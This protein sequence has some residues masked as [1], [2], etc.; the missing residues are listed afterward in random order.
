MKMLTI[1]ALSMLTNVLVSSLGEGRATMQKATGAGKGGGTNTVVDDLLGIIKRGTPDELIA[2]INA[3]GDAN[4]VTNSGDSLL[5]HAI[6]EGREDM[7][8]ALMNSGADPEMTNKRGISATQMAKDKNM[9]K[10]VDI[11]TRDPNAGGSNALHDAA[12]AGDLDHMQ[13]L[14]D[15]GMD[16]N[17]VDDAGRTPMHLAAMGG[18]AAAVQLLKQCDAVVSIKDNSGNTPSD[19]ANIMDHKEV[20]DF[21]QKEQQEADQRNKRVK[22]ALEIR[23]RNKTCTRNLP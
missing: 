9:Q 5:H 3:G 22:K 18:S 8:E 6:Q 16:V 13:Q 12:F 7:I 15:N 17:A 21:L 1:I 19:Y 23:A 4:H 2:K 10:A 11:L 20:K 14:I